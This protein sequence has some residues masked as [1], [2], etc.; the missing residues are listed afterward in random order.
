MT[1]IQTGMF[2]AT[3]FVSAFLLFLVQPMFAKMML[4]VLGGT[5]A[6]WTTC[7]LFFQAT[8]LAGYGYAHGL[9]KIARLPVQIGVHVSLVVLAFLSLPLM[10]PHLDASPEY[11]ALWLLGFSVVSIGLPFLV[12]SAS[13]P[14]LQSWFSQTGHP[15]AHN[16][17]FLY[18][19]SNIGSICNICRYVRYLTTVTY[20]IICNYCIS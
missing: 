15:N 2:T 20:K 4:P 5:A 12:L 8:L 16:P 13:A 18:A 17:Y 9:T 1:K 6:V 10:S 3:I 14:L 7:M 11:P 19:A